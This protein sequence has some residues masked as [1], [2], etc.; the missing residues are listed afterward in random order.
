M[1]FSVPRDVGLTSGAASDPRT[2][3]LQG[4]KCEE[5]GRAGCENSG[6]CFCLIDQ[7]CNFIS[8]FIEMIAS[9]FAHLLKALCNFL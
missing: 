1:A 8:P 6:R 5:L 7:W 4:S 9:G 2:Q 3:H